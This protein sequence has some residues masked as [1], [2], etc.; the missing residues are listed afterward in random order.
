PDN[1][2]WAFVPGSEVGDYCE[3]LD[4]AYQR[5]VGPYQVQRTWSNAAAKAGHDPCVP[6]PDGEIYVAAAPVLPDSISIQGF[7]GNVTT[8]GVTIPVGMSKTIDVKLY[9]DAPLTSD[10]FRVDAFD[11]TSFFGAS[12]PDLTFSW[13]RTWGRNGDT[14]HLTITRMH[15]PTELP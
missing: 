4:V 1:Y 13:D 11:L 12:P 7:N 9:S 10:F 6:A 8:K 2:V 14:L 15:A 3:Y 5:D